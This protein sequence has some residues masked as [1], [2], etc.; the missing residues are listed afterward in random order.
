MT[1]LTLENCG[2]YLTIFDIT[3]LS[4]EDVGAEIY[5]GRLK[6]IQVILVSL[7]SSTCCAVVARCGCL[8]LMLV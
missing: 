8:I 2:F 5:T 1:Y 4:D 6:P 3:S 7:N